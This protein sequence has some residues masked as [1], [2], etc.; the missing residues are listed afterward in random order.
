M[1]NFMHMAHIIKKVWHPCSLHWQDS[2]TDRWIWH[3][4]LWKS[5]CSHLRAFLGQCLVYL[6]HQHLKKNTYI[7]F[8][9]SPLTPP[10]TISL[11]IVTDSQRL[12]S[13]MAPSGIRVHLRPS[14]LVCWRGRAAV[15]Q[16]VSRQGGLNLTATGLISAWQV[17]SL[18]FCSLSSHTDTH[19]LSS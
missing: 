18:P 19:S 5:F 4:W 6:S 9:L 7:S 13:H 11:L 16:G 8:W 3:C 15:A 12:V 17:L 10:L 1:L 2:F 14:V